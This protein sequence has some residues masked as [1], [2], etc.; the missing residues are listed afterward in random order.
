MVF[1]STIWLTSKKIQR[2]PLTRT[3]LRFVPRP[4]RFSVAV[5]LPGL[6]E[7]DVVPGTTCGRVLITFST[8]TVPES[9]NSSSLTTAIGAA[10]STLR[11]AMREPVTM[12]GSPISSA[13]TVGAA[14]RP[15][16]FGSSST[17]ACAKTGEANI[18]PAM[19]L[20]V[21]SEAFVKRLFILIPFVV[22][23]P[24][25]RHGNMFGLSPGLGRPMRQ[26]H[27]A[28]MHRCFRVAVCGQV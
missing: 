6:F 5:P 4:R 7:K 27:A 26:H 21:S 13:S 2:R 18:A 9:W 25:G 15:G 24:Y 16:S 20:P 28:A 12:I 1:K 11:R 10:V 23:A 17:C 19:M 8:L 22:R 14:C 3:R